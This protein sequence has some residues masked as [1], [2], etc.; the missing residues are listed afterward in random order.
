MLQEFKK[1]ALRGSVVDLAVGMIIGAAFTSIVKS[2]VTDIF[3]PLLGLIIGGVD[4]AD[5]F[6][7]LKGQGPFTT[8]AEADAAGAITLNVG[9]FFNACLQFLLVSIA[10]FFVVKQFQRVM[11]KEEQA[12]PQEAPAL[13]KNIVLL[14]EIR[15]L[16][17]AQNTQAKKPKTKKSTP[18]KK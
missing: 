8:L 12:P 2:L 10:I 17:Q 15:D 16:L 14:T 11:K 3:N 9:L 7:V 13:P 5:F 18:K 1:F 4:F 6:V